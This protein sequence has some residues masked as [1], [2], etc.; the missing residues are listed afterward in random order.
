[1]DRLKESSI[2]DFPSI[3]PDCLDDDVLLKPRLDGIFAEVEASLPS[4]DFEISD[5]SS[6]TLCT[7]PYK[8]K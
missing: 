8:S 2:S 1:M 4:I 3:V 7:L 5:V 6:K